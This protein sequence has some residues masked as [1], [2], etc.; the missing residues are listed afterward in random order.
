MEQKK[1]KKSNGKNTVLA[2]TPTGKRGWIREDW[3]RKRTEQHFWKQSMWFS[4]LQIEKTHNRTRNAHD[5]I[6][7]PDC[8]RVTF[9]DD[10]FT[11]SPS[12]RFIPIHPPI[13]MVWNWIFLSLDLMVAAIVFSRV[14]LS[15]CS[16]SQLVY[17]NENSICMRNN[18]QQKSNDFDATKAKRNKSSSHTQ[19]YVV[20]THG[21]LVHSSIMNF[22]S[23]FPHACVCMF[24][25]FCI[26]FI[27]DIYT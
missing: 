3:H 12:L 10:P 14:A 1:T 22:P 25:Y 6:H 9:N 16:L 8:G 2:D 24:V 20:H 11:V 4:C 5:I 18:I 17:N 26:H 13:S 27:A 19:N 15:L 23:S 21:C 7:L